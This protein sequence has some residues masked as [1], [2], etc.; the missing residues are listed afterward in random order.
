MVAAE[1]IEHIIMPH[2]DLVLTAKEREAILELA[3]LTIAWDGALAKAELDA[4]R[5]IALHL[6]DMVGDPSVGPKSKNPK[7]VAEN[8]KLTDAELAKLLAEFANGL[9][10]AAADERL[11]SLG[12]ALSRKEAATFAYEIACALALIDGDAGD[13]EFELELQL[14]DALSL[15]TDEAETL[16][17]RTRTLMLG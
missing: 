6:R 7:D 4:F 2:E 15:D 3:Y 14:L 16:A 13:A 9:D 5:I 1:K 11:L 8:K 17:L 10:R 12:P